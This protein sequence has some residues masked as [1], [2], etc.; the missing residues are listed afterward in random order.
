MAGFARHGKVGACQ[1]E[2]APIVHRYCEG[3]HSEPFYSMAVGAILDGIVY[4][5]VPM[6]KVFMAIR[7]KRVLRPRVQVISV[8]IL[9][10]HLGMLASEWIA[11]N[12]MIECMII[13]ESEGDGCVAPLAD[14]SE[15]SV[16]NVAMAR[17]AVQELHPSVFHEWLSVSN[18]IRMA[19]RAFDSLMS[20]RKLE[21]GFIVVEFCR[22]LE[23]GFIMA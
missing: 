14:F 21:H 11:G 18:L 8:T 15:S 16:V 10:S 5:E 2:C 4:P 19:L 6:M 23:A 22:R 20:S 1:L 17:D 9:A 7:A 12:V 3:R 13:Y